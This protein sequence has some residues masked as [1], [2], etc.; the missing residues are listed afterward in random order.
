[1][2]DSQSEPGSRVGAEAPRE[3]G[4]GS[5]DVAAS[6][7]PRPADF[8]KDIRFWAI[9]LALGFAGSLTAL[10]ATITSTALPSIINDLN[11]AELYIWANNGYF[12]AM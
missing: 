5:L 6:D 4:Q 7:K 10:E 1:M 2:P 9:F 11:G 3:H 8:H 12:L